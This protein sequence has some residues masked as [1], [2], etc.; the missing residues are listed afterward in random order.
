MTCPGNNLFKSWPRTPPPA[1]GALLDRL[2]EG[3]ARPGA[4]IETVV[5]GQ[6][7]IGLRAGG[8]I[9]LASTLGAQPGPEDRELL[10]RLPGQKLF[11][12]AELLWGDRPYLVSLGLAGL[13]AGFDPPPD[14]PGGDAGE[15][16]AR[17]GGSGEVVLVGDFPFI[18]EVSRR[19]KRLHV[20]E[21]K[22]TAGRLPA[23]E[24]PDVL[25][26]CRVAGLT[27]TTLL[28]RSL[29]YFLDAAP[30]AVKVLIGPSTPWA[31]RLFDLG[32]DVLAGSV[33]TRPEAVLAA[34]QADL[35]FREIKRAGARPALWAPEAGRLE[36]TTSA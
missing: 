28:T 31:A 16:L 30:Q 7:F 35:S 22:D 36:R 10:A 5:A 21:L 3:L 19:V 12:A 8:R 27:A 9:G 13:N 14:L 33:V 24:W 18:Q 23:Q 25:R 20:F 6:R 26:R 29:A 17:L 1:E 4:V 15:L 34:I 11:Q 2:L 32:L